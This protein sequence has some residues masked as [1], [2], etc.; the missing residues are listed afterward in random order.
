MKDNAENDLPQVGIV[1]P[2]TAG[3]S[4]LINRLRGRYNVVLRH[5]AQEHSYVQTMWQRINLPNWLVFLDVSYPVSMER[6]KL[7]WTPAEYEEQQR[8]LAHARQHADFYLMTDDLTP[9]QVAEKV[10]EFLAGKGI[11]RF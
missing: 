2:C 5:I 11:E 6:K 3:K 1:G 8:R 4:T 10:A 7:D 9:D